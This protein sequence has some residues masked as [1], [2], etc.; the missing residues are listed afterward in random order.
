MA[1]DIPLLPLAAVS[2]GLFALL[3]FLV[4]VIMKLRHA[5]RDSSASGPDRLSEEAFAAAT[6]QAAL[7]SRTAPPGGATTSAMSVASTLSVPGDAVDGALLEALPSGVLATDEAGVVRRCTGRA[8][9]W[10]GLAGP[11]TGHPYRSTLSRWPA[12]ADAFAAAHAG[13]TP[14]AFQVAD[15]ALP[16]GRLTVTVMRWTPRAG[17]GGAMALLSPAPASAPEAPGENAPR[18]AVD[19]GIPEAARLA[20]G[21]AHEL[22]NSLTTVHGYAHMVD[23]SGLNAAD[24]TALDHITTSSEKML[25]TVDAFRALVRPLPVAPTTFAPVDAVR[26]AIDLARQEAGLPDA[27]VTLTTAPTGTVHADRVLIEEAVAAVIRNAIEATAPVPAAPPVVVTVGQHPGG[28]HV[29]IVVTDRGP[30]VPADVRARVFQPF[31]TDKPDHDGLG[32]ARTAQILRAHPGAAIALAHPP[33]GGLVV[34][35]DLPPSA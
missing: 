32:L 12:I 26:A 4:F 7:A 27:A 17:R 20:S 22:A 1:A 29:Q 13:D 3:G 30:G 21:L 35:I 18:P 14:A 15:E 19:E 33:D 16:A 5:G 28:R 10:L 8:R 2:L 34:T 31:L 6:I 23:R 9:D 11:G 25:T 24:R